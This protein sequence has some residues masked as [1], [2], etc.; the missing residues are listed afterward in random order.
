M[1]MR[2]P[3]SKVRGL[4]SARKGTGHFWMQRVTAVAN[5]FLAC[6]FI[7]LLINLVGKDYDTVREI[8]RSPLVSVPI[9]LFVMSGIY[10]MHIGMQVII[11]DYVSSEGWKVIA[12]MLNSFFSILVGLA[13]IFAV[14]R[15]ALTG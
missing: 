11:E 5:L 4:G 9:L 14:L 2:T 6:F 8:L 7:V 3:L 10:H 13:C 15:I 12:L 1:G